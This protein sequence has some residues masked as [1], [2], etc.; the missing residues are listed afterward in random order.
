M[1]DV[2]VLPSQIK[3]PRT[4]RSRPE[5]FADDWRWVV[6][7]LER[8]AALQSQTM[9]RLLCERQAGRYQE[10]QFM[11]VPAAHRYLARPVCWAG[12]PSLLALGDWLE[13]QGA[14]HSGDGVDWRVLDSDL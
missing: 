13:E 2:G 12:A 4:Y 10:G 1:S 9:F 3:Q 11:H 6:A 7:Q 8:D 14:T 5:P